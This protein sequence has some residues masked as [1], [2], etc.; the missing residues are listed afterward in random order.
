MEKREAERRKNEEENHKKEVA[1]LT[2]KA[3]QLQQQLEQ[4]LQP[5][6]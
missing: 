6:K 2:N 4:F 1:F 5:K 3:K